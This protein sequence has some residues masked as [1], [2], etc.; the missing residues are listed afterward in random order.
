MPV[1]A[2]IHLNSEFLWSTVWTSAECEGENDGEEFTL[3][4]IIGHEM[5]A[6]KPEVKILYSVD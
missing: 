2:K 1:L 5:N 6:C 3:F 4:L